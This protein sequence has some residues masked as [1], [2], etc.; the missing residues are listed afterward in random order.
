M[1]ILLSDLLNPVDLIHN[2]EWSSTCFNTRFLKLK[3]L[4]QIQSM[5]M[6]RVVT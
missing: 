6:D 1:W 2:S 3:L 4:A 5:D